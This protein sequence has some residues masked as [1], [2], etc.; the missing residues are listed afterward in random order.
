MLAK[1]GLY[2]LSHISTIHSSLII[3]EM[4]SLKLAQ[5]GL[6]PQSS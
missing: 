5:P 1:Q 2:Y 6:E 3:L 4:E